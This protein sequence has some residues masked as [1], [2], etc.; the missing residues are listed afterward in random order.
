VHNQNPKTKGKIMSEENT[1]TDIP[2]AAAPAATDNPLGGFAIAG[3]GLTFVNAYKTA[4]FGDIPGLIKTTIVVL[5]WLATVWIPYVNIWTTLALIGIPIAIARKQN[6]SPV[7][8]FTPRDKGKFFDLLPLLGIIAAVMSIFATIGFGAV[9]TTLA[10]F[11]QSA[12]H[13]IS[14]AISSG[15]DFSPPSV[16][17]LRVKLIW[18]GVTLAVPILLALSAWSISALLVLD[19]G[20]NPRDALAKS[21]ELTRGKVLTV[22]LIFIPIIVVFFV[23]MWLFAQIPYVGCILNLALVVVLGA[24]KLHI[25][26]FIWK[27]LAEPKTEPETQIPPP[28]QPASI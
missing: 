14:K 24:I 20:L 3:E 26:A 2:V 6:T 16:F 23:A 5:L 15:K 28:E 9:S 17:W 12:S 25:L 8:I 4:L 27:E 18:I 7:E 22:A 19:G 1:T 10:S 11:A 13:G 21:V